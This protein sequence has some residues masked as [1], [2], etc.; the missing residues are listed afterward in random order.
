MKIQL[1]EGSGEGLKADGNWVWGK[2]DSYSDLL[3]R[4]LPVHGMQ[5]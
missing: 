4:A 5:G 3:L 1:L 2:I